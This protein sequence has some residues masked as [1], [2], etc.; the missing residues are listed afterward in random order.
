MR[1]SSLFPVPLWWSASDHRLHSGVR[2]H[3]CAL[4]QQHQAQSDR[5]LAIGIVVSIGTQPHRAEA[6]SGEGCS[7]YCVLGNLVG[8]FCFGEGP[9]KLWP[10]GTLHALDGAT[11]G[12]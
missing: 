12:R 2:P 3:P 8:L 6:S 1:L 5:A 7:A 11:S 9:A 4:T 10:I